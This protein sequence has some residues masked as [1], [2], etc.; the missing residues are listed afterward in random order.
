MKY[1]TLS[2][3]IKKDG[4]VSPIYR[5]FQYIDIYDACTIIAYNIQLGTSVILDMTVIPN[6]FL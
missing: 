6:L 4:W 2:V 3:L 1:R 5:N